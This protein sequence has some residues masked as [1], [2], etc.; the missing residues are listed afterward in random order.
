MREVREV[1]VMADGRRGELDWGQGA[2]G[3]VVKDG[4]YV[5]E[6]PLCG[7]DDTDTFSGC[8][9]VSRRRELGGIG[10]NLIEDVLADED[11]DR[12][13]VVGLDCE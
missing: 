3:E 2:V 12:L 4:S 8:L 10:R 1:E 7:V 13:V 9:L 11:F 6:V 5:V